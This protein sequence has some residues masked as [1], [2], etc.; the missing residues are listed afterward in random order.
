MWI[1]LKLLVAVPAHL[2]YV[3]QYQDTKK[4]HVATPQTKSCQ[5]VSNISGL[6]R[7]R[8][9]NVNI[10]LVQQNSIII[11]IQVKILVAVPRF[12]LWILRGNTNI[13]IGHAPQT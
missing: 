3:S 1:K 12:E 6:C 2:I 5:S 10:K 13:V 8:D 7:A 9:R 4:P 11:H